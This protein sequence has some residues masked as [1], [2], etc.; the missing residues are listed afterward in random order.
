MPAN[1]TDWT[2]SDREK[3]V[4]LDIA[5]RAL[6]LAVTQG[7]FLDEFPA[8]ETLSQPGGAFVTLHLRG[9]LRG[10]IGQFATDQPLVRVVAHCAAAAAREDPRFQAVQPNE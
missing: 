1:S 9:R 5:R 8:D 10:C 4:L 2:N 7:V 6:I 3:L